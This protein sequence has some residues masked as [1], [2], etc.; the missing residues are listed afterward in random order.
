MQKTYGI[1]HMLRGVGLGGVWQGHFPKGESKVWVLGQ[2]GACNSAPNGPHDL[3]FC[4]AG[5]FMGYY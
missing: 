3:K 4:M 1:Y 2:V 5:G